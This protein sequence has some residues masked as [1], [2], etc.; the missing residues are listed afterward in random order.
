MACIPLPRIS[1]AVSPV[2]ASLRLSFAPN[3]PRLFSAVRASAHA[4][5][6][7]LPPSHS[8]QSA[9]RP[10]RSSPAELRP[11]RGFPAA[12]RG[13]GGGCRPAHVAVRAEG[14]D[15]ADGGVDLQVAKLFGSLEMREPY[16]VAMKV[17]DYELDQY[18]VVNNATYASYCQH[19]RHEFLASIGLAADEVARTGDALALA[20]LSL[21]YLNA[22]RSGDEFVVT[23]RVSGTTAARVFIEHTIYRLPDRERVLQGQATVVF[24]DKAYRPTRVPALFKA[25]LTQFLRAQQQQ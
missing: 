1:S 18:R 6:V 11:P 16:E 17:R 12:V 2:R 5:R 10:S 19:A 24:L 21:K 22:L 25:R 23:A 20:E 7:P 8:P 9:L 15:G 4:A 3:S 13:I 14:G